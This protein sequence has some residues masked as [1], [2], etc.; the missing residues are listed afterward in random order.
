MSVESTLRKAAKLAKAGN[1]A[2]AAALYREI[3]AKFPG[4]AAA[5]Q[6]LAALNAPGPAPRAGAMPGGALG[7]G[8]IPGARPVA[9]PAGLNGAP[10]P[11]PAKGKPQAGPARNRA[12]APAGPAPSLQQM[13]ALDR[14]MARGDFT[15]VIAE[16]QRLSLLFPQTPALANIL[17]LALGRAGRHDEALKACDR[18]IALDPG[19]AGAHVNK[20]NALSRLGRFDE[21]ETEAN[22]ALALAPDMPQAQLLLGHAYLNTGRPNEALAMFEAVTRKVPTEVLGLLGIGN[23]QTALGNHDAALSAF[24]AAHAIEPRNIDVLNN[25]GNALIVAKQIDAG[26]ASFEAALAEGAPN[27][28]LLANYARALRDAGRSEEAAEVC[29]RALAIDPGQLDI[30]NMLSTLLLAQGDREGARAALEKATENAPDDLM[31]RA[32][33]WTMNP[34]PLD[35]PDRARLEAAAQD[36]AVDASTRNRLALGLFKAFDAADTP[37]R[38]FA[39]IKLAKDI[40]GREDPFDIEAE[41]ARLRELMQLFRAGVRPLGAEDTAAIPAPARPVFIVGMPRSGTSLV[42]QILSSHSQVF[43]AG[44]LLTLSRLRTRFGWAV[45]GRPRPYDR[46]T[47]LELRRQYFD[48]LVQPGEPKPVVT[49]KTPLNFR[50]VGPALAAMPEARVLF[51]RRDARATCWSN[52]SNSFLGRANNFGN[53]MRHVARMYRIHLEFLDLW[54]ALFPDRVTVVPYEALTENQE[55][56]SRKLVAA[57]GLDWED[58]CLD[59]HKNTRFVRTVSGSQVRAKMYTGSSEAWRRYAPWLGP[60]LEELGEIDADH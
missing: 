18:L 56:E 40:R 12:K 34:M 5:R 30:W 55:E 27:V 22:A 8:L 37:D 1:R 54:R 59:F 57:V 11:K 9:P 47:L 46:D 43:G 45:G 52:Y 44:E 38:A 10:A 21:V 35:H 15:S 32:I 50:D 31:S 6:G 2:G 28:I 7:A 53:D 60:M 16:A 51:M 24:Q 39:Y 4:N 3:L 33:L 23:A 25:L 42:E 14:L 13:Q 26:I 29:R 17:A 36:E 41:E 58:A 19:F 49:D 48:D 20:A